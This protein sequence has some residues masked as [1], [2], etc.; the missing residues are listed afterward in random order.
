MVNK[1]L[2]LQNLRTHYH[3]HVIL[4][5]DCILTYLNTVH[6]FTYYLSKIHFNITTQIKVRSCHKNCTCISQSHECYLFCFNNPNS[7]T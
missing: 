3:A 2:A 1:F 6:N 7:N 4:S 5:L